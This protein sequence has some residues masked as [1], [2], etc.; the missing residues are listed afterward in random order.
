MA[1][2]GISQAALARRLGVSMARVTQWRTPL[3]MLQDVLRKATTAGDRS[4]RQLPNGTE[5][6]D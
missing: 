4:K 3:Q 6:R 1:A 2:K 5:M